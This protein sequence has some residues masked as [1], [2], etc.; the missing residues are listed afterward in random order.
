MLTDSV[1]SHTSGSALERNVSIQPLAQYVIVSVVIDGHNYEIALSGKAISVTETGISSELYLPVS[2][3][4]PQM[5]VASP[6]V[7]QCPS[8]GEVRYFNLELWG[9]IF[10][11]IAWTCSPDV[12]LGKYAAKLN[13]HFAF[14]TE[15]VHVITL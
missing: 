9:H 13:D 15:R 10:E 5:L 6:N 1:S 14:D 12:S 3:V 4:V 8:K 7:R 2:D 11:D